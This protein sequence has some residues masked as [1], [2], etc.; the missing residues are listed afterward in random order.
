MDILLNYKD[1]LYLTIR[2]VLENAGTQTMTILKRTLRLTLIFLLASLSNSFAQK[3]Y[4]YFAGQLPALPFLKGA[5]E[6]DEFADDYSNEDLGL[7]FNLGYGISLNRSFALETG[8][9][10]YLDRPAVEYYEYAIGS[11]YYSDNL[12]IRHN[13]ISLQ[14]KPV[15]NVNL[16]SDVSLR[17]GLAFNYQ[18]II[19]NATYTIYEEA[20]TDYKFKE[21]YS[22][23]VKSDFAINLQ[24]SAGVFFDVSDRWKVGLDLTYVRVDWN[25]TLDFVR[26]KQVPDLSI[27]SDKT[28]TVYAAIKVFFK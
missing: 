16:D 15:F 14:L 24:P 28:S 17:F 18:K 1:I 26:F 6:S 23:K 3:N 13:A 27:Q 11:T 4:F 12:D 22:N 25:N 5:I 21:K 19:T 10:Y 7:I 9:E 8:I 20:E 2:I